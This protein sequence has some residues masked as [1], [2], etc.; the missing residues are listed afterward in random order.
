MPCHVVHVVLLRADRSPIHL[1]FLANSLD[2]QSVSTSVTNVT[3]PTSASSRAATTTPH[4]PVVIHHQGKSPVRSVAIVAP[5]GGIGAVAF[6]AKVRSNTSEVYA[7]VRP[8]KGKQFT[9]KGVAVILGDETMNILPK[10]HPS[11]IHVVESLKETPLDAIV[12]PCVKSNRVASSLRYVGNRQV[13]MPQN[14]LGQVEEVKKQH[15]HAKLYSGNVFISGTRQPD[16]PSGQAI[17]RAGKGGHIEIGKGRAADDLQA[18]FAGQ[19]IFGFKVVSDI[20]SSKYTKVAMNCA[21]NSLATLFDTTK[22]GLRNDPRTC[23]LV[24]LMIAEVCEVGWAVGCFRETATSAAEAGK[25]VFEEWRDVV[26]L[27]NPEHPTSMQ[28]DFKSGDETELPV[29]N[30]YIAKKALDLGIHVPLNTYLAATLRGF[31]NK[32]DE[33]GTVQEF[34]DNH[35]ADLQKATEELFRIAGV[36]SQATVK[37][38]ASEKRFKPEPKRVDSGISDMEDIGVGE[39]ELLSGSA[40][41]RMLSE[42]TALGTDGRRGS[43]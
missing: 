41:L 14:G 7:V 11:S 38:D 36:S 10:Q 6:A 1:R 24:R 28:T 33:Y 27:R 29:L 8:G 12:M 42:E 26:A 32:R 16:D 17:V 22:G 43:V 19:D 31:E 9:E 40:V 18:A 34:Y 37:D 35:R 21:M 20:N 25:Q 30:Q 13:F 15:P 39:T 2:M 23:E 4:T 3:S 5:T